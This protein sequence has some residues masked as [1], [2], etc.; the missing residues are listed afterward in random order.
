MG[1]TQ[2]P[3][4]RLELLAVFKARDVIGGNRFADCDSGRLGFGMGWRQRTCETRMHVGN[5]PSQLRCRDHVILQIR[6]Y[7]LHRWI[8]QIVSRSLN[9]IAHGPIPYQPMKLYLH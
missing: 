5:E 7:D 4:D 9:L 8:D 6:N 1:D 2:M 3:P